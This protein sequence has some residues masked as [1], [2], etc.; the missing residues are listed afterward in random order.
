[1]GK[2]SNTVF[3]T[4]QILRTLSGKKLKLEATIKP[5]N[6]EVHSNTIF[7]TKSLQS[8]KFQECRHNGKIS[9]TN[10]SELVRVACETAD[11][12]RETDRMDKQTCR[13]RQTDAGDW[14]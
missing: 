2:P 13:Y 7:V 12:D 11:R 5:N 8:K 1:M 9:C 10:F 6:V 4:N 3:Y 14:G